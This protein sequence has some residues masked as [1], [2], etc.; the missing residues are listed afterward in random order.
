MSK[1]RITTRLKKNKEF[2]SVHSPSL[3]KLREKKYADFKKTKD[4]ENQKS[5]PVKFST[6][7][8]VANYPISFAQIKAIEDVSYKFDPS[9]PALDVY[10]LALC[11]GDQKKM[12]KISTAII[13]SLEE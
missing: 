9:L 1:K 7:W 3:K 4:Y 2:W 11:D 13:K 10:L 8:M 5:G 12:N 6:V